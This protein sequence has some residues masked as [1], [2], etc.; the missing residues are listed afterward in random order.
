MTKAPTPTEKS[1]KQRDNTKK[2]STKNFDY[3]TITDRLRMV[4]G[5]CLMYLYMLTSINTIWKLFMV[6]T[7]HNK[8]IYVHLRVQIKH[9]SRNKKCHMNTM[10][11]CLWH[12]NCTCSLVS[13]H[14]DAAAQFSSSCF[15]DV[16]PIMTEGTM[17]FW[18]NQRRAT[19]DSDL[20]ESKN[21]LNNFL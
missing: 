10:S 17:S 8:L 14:P 11:I 18:S 13:F 16:Q 3:T 19:W 12:A 20:P 5:K 21:I 7:K 2:N 4:E 9:C 1:K 6:T 15:I